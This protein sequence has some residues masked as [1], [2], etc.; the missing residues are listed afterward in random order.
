VDVET[1]AQRAASG[2]QTA[3]DGL[4]RGIQPEVLRRCGR[5]LPHRQ[6][7][8]EACQDALMQV[9]RNI[10]TFAGR[11]KFSTW[12]YPVVSNCA[13]QTYRVLKRR[14]AEQSWTTPPEAVE[15]RTTSVIAGCRIDLLEALDK[16][17]RTKPELV[18]PIVLRDLSQLSYPEI[19][20]LLGAPLSTVKMRIHEG[21][22]LM[23]KYMG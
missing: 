21:R 15:A 14:G 10:T 5:L 19:A 13:R 6:D 16:L 9:A 1:L 18:A 23:R 20:E 2:D 11:S 22:K 8:E 4:L 12:L 3:L 7:A 17:E